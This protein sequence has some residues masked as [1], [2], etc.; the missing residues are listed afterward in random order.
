MDI[1]GPPPGDDVPTYPFLQ[2]TTKEWA[3]KL[4]YGLIDLVN[5]G[6]NPYQLNWDDAPQHLIEN[7]QFLHYATTFLM[8]SP[9]RKEIS[10]TFNGTN[11]RDLASAGQG[12]NDFKREVKLYDYSEK[13]NSVWH[14]DSIA[15]RCFTCAR[16]PC[17]SLCAECFDAADHSTHDYSRFFSQSGGACDCGNSDILDPHGFCQHHQPN[18]IRVD[19]PRELLVFPEFVM[20]KVLLRLVA[21][22]RQFGNLYQSA[23]S[24]RPESSNKCIAESVSRNL[25][26]ASGDFI[27][28]L[29]EMVELGRPMIDVL[30]KIICDEEL[31]QRLQPDSPPLDSRTVKVA[32]VEMTLKKHDLLM[33]DLESLKP[34]PSPKC[35]QIDF[36]ELKIELKC[37]LDELIFYMVRL[38][39]P[40]NLINLLLSLL[41]NNQLKSQFSCR[42][43]EWYGLIDGL[44]YE[45]MNDGYADDHFDPNKIAARVIHASVQICSSKN[46]CIYLQE[47]VGI[48]RR[49]LDSALKVIY[50]SSTHI[51]AH[52]AIEFCYARSPI[53]TTDPEK[54]QVFNLN[55]NRFF[56][57]FGH[58]YLTTDLQ[59]LFAHIE[60][61]RDVFRSDDLSR[62]YVALLSAL[63][64]V[65]VLWR[66]V[67]GDH[68]ETDSSHLMQ[69]Y[70]T[71]E[72][73]VNSMLLFSSVVRMTEEDLSSL[74]NFAF[75]LQKQLKEWFD[76]VGVTDN[77]SKIP[78]FFCTSHIPL[79]RQFSATIL[80][81]LKLT[82]DLGVMSGL[83]QDFLASLLIHPLRIQ[84]MVSE[85][86][87]KMWVRNGNMARNNVYLY[88]QTA[89]TNGFLDLDMSLMRLVCSQL[90]GWKVMD[91]MFDAFHLHDCLNFPV[92]LALLETPAMDTVITQRE[93][94]FPMVDGFLKLFLEL[95]L[96]KS[97]VEMEVEEE[98]KLEVVHI[99][100]TNQQP[101]S[102]LR[103]NL[104]DR[105]AEFN[106]QVNNCFE[107][108]VKKVA[109]FEQPDQGN[110]IQQGLYILTDEAWCNEVDMIRARF[111]ASSPREFNALL[112]RMEVALRE[113]LSSPN[114]ARFVWPSFLIPDFEDKM[115]NTDHL[116]LHPASIWV[117]RYVLDSYLAHPQSVPVHILQQTIYILTLMVAYAVKT[118]SPEAFR[119]LNSCLDYHPD[120][121]LQHSQSSSEGLTSVYGLSLF[122]SLF[123]EAG[124]PSVVTRSMS[125]PGSGS[126]TSLI[127]E[128]YLSLHS[129][130]F[131]DIDPAHRDRDLLRICMKSPDS[132]KKM[133]GSGTE[134]TAR[135][136]CYLYNYDP[137]SRISLDKK[138]RVADMSSS[139]TVG[140]LERKNDFLEKKMAAKRRQMEIMRNKKVQNSALMS[141]L[142]EIEGLKEDDIKEKENGQRYDCPICNGSE[143]VEDAFGLFVY[144]QT[145]SVANGMIHK[146][147]TILNPDNSTTHGRYDRFAYWEKQSAA[148]YNERFG[149]NM[150]LTVST[151][152]LKVCGHFAHLKCFENY[153]TSVHENGITVKHRMSVPCPVCRSN[154]TSLIPLDIH[155]KQSDSHISEKFAFDEARFVGDCSFF[156][157]GAQDV[158]NE[159]D[160]LTMDI[161][162]Q[163][164]LANAYHNFKPFLLKLI[165]LNEHLETVNSVDGRRFAFTRILDESLL[166]NP[167]RTTIS[168]LKNQVDRASLI[169]SMKCNY[170]TR[171]RNLFTDSLLK[172]SLSRI[173]AQENNLKLLR[174]VWE[175]LN[176]R[177]DSSVPILLYD[178]STLLILLIT[179][180]TSIPS[181]EKDQ[182][183]GFY[184]YCYC[185]CL[186]QNWC[187]TILMFY[188][189]TDRSQHGSVNP[190]ADSIL[191][192]LRKL[193]DDEQN[194]FDPQLTRRSIRFD[195][196]STRINESA[197]SF[198]SFALNLMIEAGLL[199]PVADSAFHDCGMFEDLAKVILGLPIS[200]SG[201]LKMMEPKVEAW[202]KDVVPN[203]TADE[204]MRETFLTE[205]WWTPR[206]LKE[207]PLLFDSLF[208]TYFKYKCNRCGEAPSQPSICMACGSTVCVYDC[209]DISIEGQTNTVSE[210]EQHSYSCTAGV[211]CF[212]S[213]NSTMVII[214]HGG[215]CN[216]WG[217]I[218][219]DDHGEEDR[220]L[221]RG[222]KLTLST[223]RLRRL[224]ELWV[225]HDFD[226][227]VGNRSWFPVEHLLHILKEC[228]LYPN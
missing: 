190:S 177:I 88:C 221:R 74:R 75:L 126:L 219:L 226:R 15:Y 145:T 55:G 131:R 144:T 215:L 128:L 120:V 6:Y 184:R 102:K 30:S 40:Q 188:L 111:R 180:I 57:R 116:L 60:L 17:M 53:R 16:N 97:Y 1:E 11:S 164:T 206:K 169:T 85:Y 152:E 69:R 103:Q 167:F 124:I 73:E 211:G 191:K 49:V 166:Q 96:I 187:R 134:Y 87:A 2:Y 193:D 112:M 200:F 47:K 196:L 210:V 176:G 118:S 14:M 185:I 199:S 107:K 223:T 93:W 35:L 149:D 159:W 79:H 9:D 172:L 7:C 146:E 77:H 156:F 37:L 192:I 18:A 80:Q 218:Y 139:P 173:S 28:F 86:F 91:L 108:V 65:N 158:I 4:R 174:S 82:N 78:P 58:W 222:K 66:I 141:K 183:R 225:S 154:V 20:T 208:N 76:A 71:V 83:D 3:Q 224:T 94:I 227:S 22:F 117:C 220:N 194:F 140:S 105:G 150:V 142:L 23:S 228:H 207:P 205:A 204:L 59:N 202:L 143:G 157:N 24:H 67:D 68:I 135:L 21:T 26:T 213:L 43:F 8:M 33:R 72:W 179:V 127:L 216:L 109:R 168:I 19:A 113:R 38:G 27:Q 44:M 95:L 165:Q 10:L 162:N 81:Y 56:S 181:I 36:F 115:I 13:C 160:R 106:E 163:R 132:L 46:V 175:K 171:L 133:V 137:V 129:Q 201:I 25:I 212:L 130:E 122:F 217:S 54:W 99:L 203:F 214:I 151:G 100:S 209:C 51:S 31:Y 138:L 114:E 182:L 64:G 45:V 104:P 61:C 178:S 101:Y 110:Q 41:P 32:E 148:V 5:E 70:F 147:S 42:F 136:I 52:H 125:S 195:E 155:L 98:V 63:Q 62:R 12:F 89:L 198:S 90:D 189:R 48:L 34:S 92:G 153:K 29:Q 186:I 197:M 170:P 161:D 84:A 50:T 121:F 39:F 123:N 119:Y